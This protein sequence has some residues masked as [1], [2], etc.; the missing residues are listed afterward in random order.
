VLAPAPKDRRVGLEVVAAC[1]DHSR[2]R[3]SVRLDVSPR[4]VEAELLSRYAVEVVPTRSLKTADGW[5]ARVP[6]R[7]VRPVRLAGR[8]GPVLVAGLLLFQLAVM[9]LGAEAPGTQPNAASDAPPRNLASS[10]APS[11]RP[12]HLSMEAMPL[13]RNVCSGRAVGAPDP[14]CA[15]LKHS[16]P[17]SGDGQPPCPVSGSRNM[18]GVLICFQGL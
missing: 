11:A 2:V 18:A 16:V 14:R 7:V 13:L 10:A 4:D 3:S 9:G 17:P 12:T 1:A 15:Q 8:L 5:L 6:R